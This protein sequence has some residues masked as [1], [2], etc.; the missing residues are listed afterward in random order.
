MVTS[1]VLA[2]CP[3]PDLSIQ[4]ATLIRRHATGDWGNLDAEDCQENENSLRDGN[5]L[6]SSYTLGG[7]KC[8]VITEWD[9]SVTTV[10]RSDEY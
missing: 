6:L 10:L 3:T 7:V 9:R 4:I 5:R 8:Y 1:G 2:L